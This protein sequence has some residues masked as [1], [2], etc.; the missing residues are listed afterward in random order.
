VL[1][2]HVKQVAAVGPSA[3]LLGTPV[4]RQL[5]GCPD[6]SVTSSGGK[7]R[8]VLRQRMAARRTVEPNLSDRT[9]H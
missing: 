6:T 8:C 9:S 4:A 1:A 7:A 3:M 2:K 5:I